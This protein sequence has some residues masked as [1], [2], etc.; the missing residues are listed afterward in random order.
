MS[1]DDLSLQADLL[2]SSIPTTSLSSTG[3]VS[4]VD[5]YC[6][7]KRCE[8][9]I[10][11][12]DAASETVYFKP[13]VNS[14]LSV[15]SST[16]CSMA[17]QK[18]GLRPRKNSIIAKHRQLGVEA[19]FE[20]WLYDHQDKLVV[21]DIDGTVT[22]SDVRGYFESVYLGV[23]T[24]VHEGIVA[25]LHTLRE[26]FG[27]HIMFLSSRPLAH[28]RETRLLLANVSEKG[29]ELPDG[30]LFVNQETTTQAAYRELITKNTKELK[31]GILLNIKRVF[32]AASPA[33]LISAEPFVWGIGNKTADCEAY[34]SAGICNDN[35]LLIDTASRI[36]VWAAA[37][38][39]P[40]SLIGHQSEGS[41]VQ[42]EG[43]SQ[44]N[45]PSPSVTPTTKA[46]K[47]D[48]DNS[49]HHSGKPGFFSSYSDPLLLDYLSHRGN[50]DRSNVN[51]AFFR[52]M[53]QRMEDRI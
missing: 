46:A 4:W 23:Y 1:A 12:V 42:R 36:R 30:P 26:S 2:A 49:T 53:Q 25:L 52:P 8:D 28:Q 18:L 13:F 6:N 20:I 27:Y 19:T 44:S 37:K 17:L 21:M 45:R 3:E 31:S 11:Y 43:H 50:I 15:A 39:L 33:S 22:R 48:D 40:A 9:I 10:A 51:S 29:I 5:L 47:R 41:L 34:H 38:A 16:P 32:A 14:V 35:I 7:G 24:Y